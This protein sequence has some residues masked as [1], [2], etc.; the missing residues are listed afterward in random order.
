[1]PLDLTSAMTN[2]WFIFYQIVLSSVFVAK[3]EHSQNGRM[4]S[5]DESVSLMFDSI[6]DESDVD[7]ITTQSH[8]HQRVEGAIQII[9][10]TIRVFLSV[11]CPFYVL[12]LCF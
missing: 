5:N 11:R 6:D 8:L 7:K 1:M 10:D 4:N 2:I 9:C 3:G 12:N